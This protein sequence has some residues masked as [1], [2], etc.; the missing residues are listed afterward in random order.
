MVR[1]VE[2]PVVSTLGFIRMEELLREQIDQVD[3]EVWWI[4]FSVYP[5]AVS[6]ADAHIVSVFTVT[7]RWKSIN[8]SENR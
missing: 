6:A 7:D 2:V 3:R 5:D 1:T 4:I 8:E